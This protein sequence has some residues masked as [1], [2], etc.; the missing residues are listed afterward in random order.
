MTQ[1]AKSE[2]VQAGE[3]Y[4]CCSVANSLISCFVA[5]RTRPIPN[6]MAAVPYTVGDCLKGSWVAETEFCAAA[7][8]G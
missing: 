8:N 5:L 7:A 3:E 4:Q 1:V 6:T 2:A